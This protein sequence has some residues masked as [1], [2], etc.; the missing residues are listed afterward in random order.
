VN[1]GAAVAVRPCFTRSPYPIILR[2]V[3]QHGGLTSP[4]FRGSR[5]V[6]QV[7]A[8]QPEEDEGGDTLK[9]FS[10]KLTARPLPQWCFFALTVALAVALAA[11]TGL[12]VVAL[13]RR[14]LCQVDGLK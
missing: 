4:A 2:V 11:T 14:R 8:Q 1:R 7:P 9:G 5:E 10:G 12:M 3:V 13:P 6:A